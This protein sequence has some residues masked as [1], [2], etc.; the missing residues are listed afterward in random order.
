MTEQGVALIITAFSALI[1]GAGGIGV[2]LRGQS[3]ARKERAI[4]AKE[5]GELKQ[6][7]T[8]VQIATD[9]IS[10]RLEEAKKQ[11]GLAEGKAIGL[12]QGRKETGK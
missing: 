5:R 1:T 8:A 9:G 2:Q 7:M 12:E 3:I 4:A 6:Q 11:Q 10:E